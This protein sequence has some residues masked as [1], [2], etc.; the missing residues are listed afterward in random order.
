VA[1]KKTKKRQAFSVA[2]CRIS[3]HKKKKLRFNIVDE[4]KPCAN[5]LDP[6]CSDKFV[7][8]APRRD[9]LARFDG[10]FLLNTLL[11]NTYLNELIDIKNNVKFFVLGGQV[12]S[13]Q[14]G[15]IYFYYSCKVINMSLDKM[16]SL[17]LSK[18]TGDRKIVYKKYFSAKLES[19][20]HWSQ[21]KKY[22]VICVA[23]VCLGK[24][25]ATLC[26]PG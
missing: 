18:K 17:L 23:T 14:I 13:I 11:T 21:S 2:V 6:Y 5:V 15:S 19:F 1:S 10:Y 12:L 25:E 9:N 4:I 7:I 8:Y 22:F 3:K 24:L 16:T 20:F 26:L